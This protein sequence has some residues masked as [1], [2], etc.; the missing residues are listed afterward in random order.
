MEGENVFSQLRRIARTVENESALARDRMSRSTALRASGDTARPVLRRMQC[1]AHTIRVSATEKMSALPPSA[2]FGTLLESCSQLC[3]AYR[4]KVNVLES[5]LQQYG[6]QPLANPKGIGKKAPVT[7]E[8]MPPNEE[9]SPS[10]ALKAEEMKE[11]IPEGRPST[12]PKNPDLA[13]AQKGGTPR[14]EDF[15]LSRDFLEQR[16]R[17]KLRTQ[18]EARQT[19]AQEGARLNS[20]YNRRE[21]EMSYTPLHSSSQAANC[22]FTPIGATTT[23]S[24]VTVTPGMFG[25]T[26]LPTETPTQ[27]IDIANERPSGQAKRASN[28]MGSFG[29]KSLHFAPGSSMPGGSSILDAIPNH[30][31]SETFGGFG[32]PSPPQLTARWKFTSISVPPPKQPDPP[33]AQE[34]MGNPPHLPEKPSMSYQRPNVDTPPTPEMTTRWD[35]RSISAMPKA[36]DH[37]TT[38]HVPMEAPVRLITREPKQTPE[39]PQRLLSSSAAPTLQDAPETPP[40]LSGKFGNSK[41]FQFSILDDLPQTPE[42]TMSYTRYVDPSTKPTNLQRE[43]HVVPAAEVPQKQMYSLG[44]SPPEKME[45]PKAPTSSTYTSYPSIREVSEAEFE[46][47][48]D[49]IRQILPLSLVNKTVIRMN[50]L[51][52]DKARAGEGCYLTD[53]DIQVLEL[54]AK[55]KAMLLFLIKARCLTNRKVPGSNSPAYHPVA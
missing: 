20:I 50:A 2:E 27:F 39:E 40:G 54:G 47:Q 42:L 33:L 5:Y 35:S 3:D 43:V 19:S 31:A 38:P 49:Y 36:P 10:S 53:A 28:Q 16:A 37:L 30:L 45:P 1:D 12:P 46:S 26:E 48:S 34:A 41:A 14:L 8:T 22:P 15:G 23:P 4:S 25:G 6:Y 51:L 52:Q 44:C 7:K 11:N 24:R 55:S 17:D 29:P 9:I 21:M 18:Q 32:T 13:P